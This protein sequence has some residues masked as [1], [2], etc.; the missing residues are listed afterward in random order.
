MDVDYK[1]ARERAFKL[2]IRRAR[3]RK[4]HEVTITTD[5]LTEIWR[6]Q[7][8]RCSLTGLRMVLFQSDD[9]FVIR[10]ASLD[11]I[12]PA[13]GYTKD[14]TSF[15]CIRANIMKGNLTMEQFQWVC[16]RVVDDVGRSGVRADRRKKRRAART[17]EETRSSRS[18]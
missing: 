14:N 15:A 17:T 1:K 9:G 3:K 5:D 8:G 10:G 11:R 6:K 13:V 18:P 2:L 16:K 4:L 12:D 7:K